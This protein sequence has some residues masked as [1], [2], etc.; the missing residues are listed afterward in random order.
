LPWFE[1]LGPLRQV[2]LDLGGVVAEHQHWVT[3]A[4]GAH[5]PHQAIQQALALHL[6]Q[7]LGPPAHAPAC[8][9]SKD[10]HTDTLGLGR[11]RVHW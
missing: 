7:T 1:V 3:Q 8:A 10:E 9:R 4:Q 6:Q 5:R 11:C 2:R